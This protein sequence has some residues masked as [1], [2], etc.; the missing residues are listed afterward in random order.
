MINVSNRSVSCWKITEKVEKSFCRGNFS[1]CPVENLFFVRATKK[2]P[3]NM[4]GKVSR[5]CHFRTWSFFQLKVTQRWWTD[6]LLPRSLSLAAFLR[7]TC[8]C[9][10][11]MACPLRLQ[12]ESRYKDSFKFLS[13]VLELLTLLTDIEN[14]NAKLG[15]VK[16]GKCRELYLIPKLRFFQFHRP[17]FSMMNTLLLG[18][19]L[20]V[21][22]LPR[23]NGSKSGRR[24]AVSNILRE[25]TKKKGNVIPWY[26]EGKS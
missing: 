13:L 5:P 14:S 18:T 4:P 19:P 9:Y 11:F 20:F 26:S 24:M 7:I 8:C 25:Q 17:T 12:L 21:M 10:A 6:I 23:A 15:K 1:I 3:K 22:A 2:C 16:P